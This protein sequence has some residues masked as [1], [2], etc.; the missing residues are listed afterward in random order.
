[1][2]GF[3]RYEE[4]MSELG[5]FKTGKSCLYIK[6]IDDIDLTVLKDLIYSSYEY[7]TKKYG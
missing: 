2:P 6:G 7:M 4:K 5:K 1:M 3:D